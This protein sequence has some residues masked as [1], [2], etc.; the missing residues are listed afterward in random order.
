MVGRR[1]VGY[2]LLAGLAP[3]ILTVALAYY[4]YGRG[5]R[6]EVQAHL[7]DHARDYGE[8]LLTRLRDLSAT[9]DELAF[10]LPESGTRRAGRHA[11]ICCATCRQRGSSVIAKDPEWY[12]V[13]LLR[14]CL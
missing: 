6:Q 10:L 8:E 2:F 4:E 7:S 5:L 14:Q 1:I 11:I 3:L 9:A 12:S 13:M